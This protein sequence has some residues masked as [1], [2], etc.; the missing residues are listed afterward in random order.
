[1]AISFTEQH[2]KFEKRQKEEALTLSCIDFMRAVR[3]S[4]QL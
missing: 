1:M 3:I 2:H 4:K